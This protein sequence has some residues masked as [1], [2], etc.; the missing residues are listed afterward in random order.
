MRSRARSD[1]KIKMNKKL[2]YWKV[3]EDGF[4][5]QQLTL[6]ICV[7]KYFV[8]WN[9]LFAWQIDKVATCPFVLNTSKI[10]IAWRTNNVQNMIKLIEIVL[11][12]KQW[13]VVE[14]LGQYTADTPNVDWL[15]VTFGVKHDLRS[16]I[17]S[18]GDVLGE[19]ASVI[20]IGIS[21]SCQAK[22]TYLNSN[23]EIET[24]NPLQPFISLSGWLVGLLTLRSQ[25][26]FKSKLLGFK[27]RC[28]TFAEWIYLSPRNIWY[29]K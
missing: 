20:M 25:L 3:L 28:N 14:H 17:P 19:K 26:V 24:I 12:R 21:D 23:Y 2:F 11:A 15:V 10:F 18:C 5:F 9:F 27:S 22:V 6:G 1:E 7:R 16:T 29:K 4:N 8:K 13:F